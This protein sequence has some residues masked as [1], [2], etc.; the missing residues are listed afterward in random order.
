LINATLLPGLPI[1]ASIVLPDRLAH[2][3]AIELWLRYSFV[4]LVPSE[5]RFIDHSGRHRHGT[6]GHRLLV[7]LKARFA[8]SLYA[9]EL[10]WSRAS[11]LGTFSYFTFYKIV[12][13]F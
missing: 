13:L 1:I 6:V 9:F 12:V 4:H 2:L 10:P 8:A 7:L 5:I 11:S 3:P